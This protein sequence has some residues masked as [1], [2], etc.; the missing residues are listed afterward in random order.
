M[1]ALE[2]WED[3]FENLQQNEE[4]FEVRQ[5]EQDKAMWMATWRLKQ[6]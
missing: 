2:V 5:Q 3:Q 4:D 1:A 6:T